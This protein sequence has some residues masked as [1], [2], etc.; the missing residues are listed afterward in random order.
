MSNS[1]AAV[2][3]IDRLIIKA[4]S[5]DSNVKLKAL[6][7]I[8]G[9][10]SHACKNRVSRL[11]TNGVVRR[12]SLDVSIAALGFGVEAILR[13]RPEAGERE[14]VYNMLVQMK[15]VTH[16]DTVGGDYPFHCRACAASL[17][18]LDNRLDSIKKY[19]YVNVDV[20]ITSPFSSRIQG[21]L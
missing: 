7:K 8:V 1:P 21:L 5:V 11:L 3:S 13:I 12:F 6:S 9:L 14:N 10:S 18:E 16:F 19:A 4:L 15:N 2:D 17:E 20:V